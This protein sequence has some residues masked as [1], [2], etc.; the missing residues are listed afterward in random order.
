[1]DKSSATWLPR[2]RALAS[3]AVAASCIAVMAVACGG[4]DKRSGFEAAA[5][6]A[7]FEATTA[8]NPDGEVPCTGLE[9]KRVKCDA[10]G[11]SVEAAN[12]E[13]LDL[14]DSCTK[15]RE[16]KTGV[17]SPDS[18]C[19]SRGAVTTTITGKVYDPAGA[20][21]L[22]N[23]LVYIPS[24]PE[25]LPEINEGVQCTTCASIAVNPFV[26]TL[27]N[28]KGE[29]ELV[30]VPV[31]KDV[32]I[33]V[34]IGKWR[35]S[36][37]FDVTKSC[38]QN[39]VPDRDFRLPKNGSEGSMP[40]IAVTSGG[41]DAL[42][43]LLHGMGIDESEFVQGPGGTGHV[44]VYNGDGGGFPDEATKASTP[45]AETLWGDVEQM[46]LYDIVMMSC[47][48]STADSNKT[49]KQALIDYANMGGKV[50]GTH[51][52]YTWMKNAPQDDWKALANW[53]GGSGSD[54]QYNVDTSFPKGAALAD[55]LVAVNASSSPGNISLT[56]VTGALS[57]VN[58]P[59]QA[60]IKKGDNA[61][62]YFS[63]NTP[64]DQPEENQCGRVVYGDL[65]LM[66]NGLS[67]TDWPSG[68]PSAG[69]LAAQQKALE[70]MFYDLSNCV[71]SD[72]TPPTVPK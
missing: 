33:V 51:F 48:C 68:C 32:P 29:F 38:N 1:M 27:T 6:D 41:C 71:Q 47:E 11:Y 28:T 13:G 61:V 39:K 56:G 26:A 66:G 8:F 54:G 49:N 25:N 40:Q 65:H 3:V 14:G 23:V 67:S 24:D 53:S 50:F 72:D 22:Y 37:T 34:Q 70:F 59:S 55:W 16:C 44:H 31:D 43:C 9:C 42:E 12:E 69:G 7:G 4:A 21:P 52:H 5:E 17:C 19:V 45:G 10:K 2:I 18:E 62:R 57:N 46:K 58:A 60:W 64:L 63:F 35:R 15:G 20:N 30:D 36:F